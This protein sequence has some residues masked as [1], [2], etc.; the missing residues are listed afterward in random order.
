MIKF[1]ERSGIQGPYLNIVKAIYSLPVANIK[2][3]REKLAAITLKSGTRQGCPLSPY[4]F[5]IVLEVLATAIKQKEFKGIQIGK[6]EVKISLFSDY[7]LVYLSDIQN[8]IIHGLHV[9]CGLYVGIW[10]FWANICLS[11]RAFHVS[12]FC[13]CDWVTSLRM[14]FSSSICLPMNFI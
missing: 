6:E 5:N 2:L 13:V 11:M 9:V 14:I 1:L 4:L 3:N 7:M 12:V 10:N 8:S